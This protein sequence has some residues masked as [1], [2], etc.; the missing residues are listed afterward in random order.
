MT[1][2]K[3]RA[4][5]K[6]ARRERKRLEQLRRQAREV[7]APVV[8]ASIFGERTHPVRH[9]SPSRVRKIKGTGRGD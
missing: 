2:A 9:R 1:T 5:R 3:R 6:L 8:V 7:S 4:S